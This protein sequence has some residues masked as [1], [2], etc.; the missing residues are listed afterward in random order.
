MTNHAVG[1]SYDVLTEE[2]KLEAVDVTVA[3]AEEEEY[4]RALAKNVHITAL[5][6]NMRP[7]HPARSIREN[8]KTIGRVE[9]MDILHMAS[10]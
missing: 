10:E 8:C 3:V 2:M 5:Q 9:V 6:A 1:K 4:L 7:P